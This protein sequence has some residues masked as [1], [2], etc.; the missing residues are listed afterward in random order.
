MAS[1]GP[2]GT[3][4]GACSCRIVDHLGNPISGTGSFLDPYVLPEGGGGGLTISTDP[5]NI[6]HLGGDGG[7]YASDDDC[8][9]PILRFSGDVDLNGDVGLADVCK[10]LILD[11]AEDTSDVGLNV[12]SN[13]QVAYP[14]GI[15][16]DG[17]SP[18]GKIAFSNA[19]GVTIITVSAARKTRIAA[20]GF[21]LIKTDTD[22][23]YLFGDLAP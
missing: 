17:V 20:A 1:V 13:A 3:C 15:R 8:A 18:S 16:F 5:G 22:E 10:F 23:W 7:I 12:C 6:I 4:G 19:G 2:C 9:Q 14:I 21:T 11:K